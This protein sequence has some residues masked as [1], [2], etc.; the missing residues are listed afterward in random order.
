[1]C[2]G[3]HILTARGK[4]LLFVLWSELFVSLPHYW[5]P[6]L[7][8][9]ICLWKRAWVHFHH[10]Q[11]QCCIRSFA[12]MLNNGTTVMIRYLIYGHKWKKKNWPAED[13]VFDCPPHSLQRKFE[14]LRCVASTCTVSSVKVCHSTLLSLCTKPN[15]NFTVSHIELHSLVW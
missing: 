4:Q 9:L 3:H 11:Y 12:V 13:H 7:L 14:F 5:C 1:M 2:D 10:E 15:T 8:L 6:E